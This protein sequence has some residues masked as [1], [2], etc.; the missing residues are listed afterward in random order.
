[1]VRS[2]QLDRSQALD[3]KPIAAPVLAREPLDGGG[4]RITVSYSPPRWQQWLLRVPDNCSKKFELDSFGVE[5]LELCD[6]K[7]SVRAIIKEFAKRHRL[8]AHEARKAVIT[9]VRT[10]IAKGVLLMAIKAAGGKAK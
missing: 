7:R 2:S 10:L 8:E 5:M 9:F 1:M 4:Q 6:G 3:A